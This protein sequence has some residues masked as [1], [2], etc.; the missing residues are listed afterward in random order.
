M[1]F[2]ADIF[3]YLTDEDT[4]AGFATGV[5]EQLDRSEARRDKTLDQLRTYGLEKINR[6]EQEYMNDLDENEE[7]V[8][9]LAAKLATPEHS[10]N[11]QQVLAA[12][13]YLIQNFTLGQITLITLKNQ[14]I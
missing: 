7:Q 14:K 12:A 3:D 10:A 8:K 6:Q 4:V 11:S 1:K 2:L 13:Q 5:S 9:L